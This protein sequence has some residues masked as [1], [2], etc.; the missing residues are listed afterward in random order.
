LL[1]YRW[2]SNKL[3]I[4]SIKS[5]FYKYEMLIQI[6]KKTRVVK[7]GVYL[8]KKYKLDIV[9]SRDHIKNGANPKSHTS[10]KL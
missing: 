1:K 5:S 7:Y 4:N 2:D 10:R 6:K 3:F 8:K 9:E